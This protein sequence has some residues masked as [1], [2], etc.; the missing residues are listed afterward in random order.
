LNLKPNLN[1]ELKILEKRN[2]K[3]IRKSREKGKAAQQ[4]N[5]AQPGRA[6]ARPRRLTGGPRLSAATFSLAL[7]PLG[8][9]CRCQLLRPRAS[10]FSLCLADPRCQALSRCPRTPLF[11]LCAVDP[12]Y[13]FRP[14]HPRRGPTRAHSRTSPEFSATTPTH[15]PQLPLMSPARA[16][17]HSPAS[18]RT[19]PPSLA[20]CPRRQTP[21]ETRASFPGHPARRRPRQATPS[22][23][24]R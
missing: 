16:R 8:P 17:T 14:S 18:F 19:V 15:V 6:P 5:S 7:C 4:P 12:P 9:T 23:A 2:R 1:L 11:S 3:G 24:P 10:L 22:S 21:P 20:L 13:Q